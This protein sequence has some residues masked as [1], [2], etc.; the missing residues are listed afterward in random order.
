MSQLIFAT[1]LQYNTRGAAALNF[2][3]FANLAARTLRLRDLY[4]ELDYQSVEALLCYFITGS[5][6]TCTKMTNV[7]IVR[8]YF[9]FF[10]HTSISIL[11]SDS[12]LLRFNKMEYQIRSN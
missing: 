1:A 3:T 10:L 4:V 12:D 9:F 11:I 8:G 7:L 2:T 6:R 5:Q